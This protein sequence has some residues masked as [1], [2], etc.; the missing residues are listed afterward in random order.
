MHADTNNCDNLK[1][2]NVSDVNKILDYYKLD[3]SKVKD[4]WEPKKLKI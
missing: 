4:I 3:G 1:F 2:F